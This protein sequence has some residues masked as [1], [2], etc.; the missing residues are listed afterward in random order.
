MPGLFLVQL[1]IFFVCLWCF[2]KLEKRLSKLSLIFTPSFT[3]V[4]SDEKP[5][6]LL[7]ITLWGHGSKNQRARQ[8]HT[9]V[10]LLLLLK[11][12]NCFNL[13]V[14]LRWTAGAISLSFNHVLIKLSRAL[15]ASENSGL[16]IIEKHLLLGADRWQL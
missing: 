14:L 16:T 15:L 13:T 10:R 7:Y 6:C 8:L 12:D 4:E 1:E 3:K 9:A 11:A 2:S 5:S